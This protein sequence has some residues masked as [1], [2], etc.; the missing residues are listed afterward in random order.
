MLAAVR[1]TIH[2]DLTS[3][4]SDAVR[5]GDFV[6]IDIPI[7]LPLSGPRACDLSPHG[8]RNCHSWVGLPWQVQRTTGVPFVTQVFWFEAHDWLFVLMMR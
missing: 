3:I 7:G 5:D 4:F 2:A 8:T 1:F 6:V